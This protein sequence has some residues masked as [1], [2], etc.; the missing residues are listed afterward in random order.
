MLGFRQACLI[1]VCCTG[2]AAVAQAQATSPQSAWGLQG[3]AGIG[4]GD[5][6]G[7]SGTVSLGPRYRSNLFSVRATLGAGPKDS[8]EHREKVWEVGATYGRRFCSPGACY[9]FAI[10]PGIINLATADSANPGQRIRKTT[11]A[12]LWQLSLQGTISPTSSIGLT[13]QGNRNK[14]QNFW[15]LFAGIQFGMP[16]H[17]GSSDDEE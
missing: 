15:A 14:L 12:L 8:V 1:F 17:S 2:W 10:G 4:G 11:G 16:W 7:F 5:K 9:G 3:A 13:F 6:L